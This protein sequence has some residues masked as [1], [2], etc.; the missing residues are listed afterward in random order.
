MTGGA[1]DAGPCAA[2]ATDF[3]ADRA[4]HGRRRPR[5]V[6]RPRRARPPGALLRADRRR[7]V[8]VDDQSGARRT[9][10]RNDHRRGV[11]DRGGHRRAGRVRRGTHRH[12]CGRD[13]FADPG[14]ADC[15]QLQHPAIDVRQPERD[16]GHPDHGVPA[17]R[18][19]GGAAVR[20]ADRRRTGGGVQ[21]PA[22]SQESARGPA[23]RIRR[24]IDRAARHSGPDLLSQHRFGVT[25]SGLG[26][27]R[28]RPAAAVLGESHRSPRHRRAIGARLPAPVAV[29][30]RGRGRRPPGGARRA[31]RQLGVAAGADPDVGAHPRRPARRSVPRRGRRPT[32][33][34]PRWPPATRKPLL[35]MP[36]PRA[37]TARRYPRAA[38]P[39]W[40]S[41]SM[42]ASTN[43]NMPSAH[44]VLDFARAAYCA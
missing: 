38:R 14:G 27:V 23:R 31:V 4:D 21:H 1:D 17:H 11:G 7:G 12:G 15:A 43:C 10:R 40:P 32:T 19:R 28:R 44:V 3:V 5:L 13:A 26:A 42:R 9:G 39:A 8:F 36:S 18:A 25:G 24:A 20:R 33:P 30:R 22:V 35:H 2:P 41:S 29:A 37:V 16:L 6:P 34:S